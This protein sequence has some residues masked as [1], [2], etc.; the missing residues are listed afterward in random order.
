TT[1]KV[2]RDPNAQPVTELLE[3]YEA[4]CGVLTDAAAD[5]VADSTISVTQLDSWLKE[6]TDGGRDFVLVD[7]RE[8]VEYEINQIPGS[9]LIPKGEFESGDALE[10]LPQDKQVVLHCK[11]GGRSA[12]CL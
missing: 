8:P 2:G 12:E 1:L 5:A 10:K 7:V 6:R 4:F 11:T 3:D 9:V